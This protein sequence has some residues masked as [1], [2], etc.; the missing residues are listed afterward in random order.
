MEL[1]IADKK[2]LMSLMN[3]ETAIEQALNQA[4]IC[5]LEGFTNRVAHS[6]PKEV[7]SEEACKLRVEKAFQKLFTTY[8]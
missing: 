1:F 6:V 5:F 2:V 8:F 4:Y 7:I 3:R